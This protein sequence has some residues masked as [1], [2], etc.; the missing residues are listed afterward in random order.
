MTNPTNLNSAFYFFFE[1]SQQTPIVK[2]QKAKIAS[3]QFREHDQ[4]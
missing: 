4:I 1:I 3:I 2:I